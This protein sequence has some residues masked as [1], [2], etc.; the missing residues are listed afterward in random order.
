L[1]NSKH[2]KTK[3]GLQLLGM[4][5]QQKA[6]V[7]LDAGPVTASITEN[8]SWLP[9]R[10]RL[11]LITIAGSSRTVDEAEFWRNMRN[12]VAQTLIDA[13]DKQ[14]E[15]AIN[16]R[17]EM[18]EMRED[19]GPKTLV[20]KLD[21]YRTKIRPAAETFPHL[22]RLHRDMPLQERVSMLVDY[23]HEREILSRKVHAD[24]KKKLGNRNHT[25][26]IEI[27]R[28]E[29]KKPAAIH[30][31]HPQRFEHYLSVNERAFAR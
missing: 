26:N 16:H 9:G 10:N 21:E 4:K 6:G 22:L 8:I 15:D 29:S 5:D 13:T 24:W 3:A 11:E 31:Q 25:A 18:G 28:I 17:I 7:V 27:R 12:P 1:N 30:A 14:V 20:K 19:D 2:K 23:L